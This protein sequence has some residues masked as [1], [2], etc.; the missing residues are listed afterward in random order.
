MSSMEGQHFG[1]DEDDV[2]CDCESDWTWSIPPTAAFRPGKELGLLTYREMYEKV[3]A[4]HTKVGGES[5]CVH[6]RLP[7]GDSR[8]GA[9]PHIVQFYCGH[10]RDYGEQC[11]R[12]PPKNPEALRAQRHEEK[13]R[14]KFTDCH[15]KCT[16]RRD[17]GPDDA[18]A[19]VRPA[20]PGHKQVTGHKMHLTNETKFLWYFDSPQRRQGIS[21]PKQDLHNWT[22]T[23]HLKNALPTG[24]V[25][26]AILTYIKNQV[27][28]CVA[29]PS[30]QSSILQEFGVYISDAQLYAALK[31]CNFSVTADGLIY[32][33]FDAP[34][35]HET[36]CVA[37]LKNLVAMKDHKVCVL[38]ENVEKST[39]TSSVFETYVKNFDS[40]DFVLVD[41][42]YDGTDCCK[43]SAPA[44]SGHVARQDEM[45][46]NGRIYDSARILKINGQQV[47]FVSVVW[48]QE[49]ELRNFSAFPEVLVMDDKKKTNK[50]RHSFFACIGVDSLWR[51]NTLFRAWSPNN[52]HD[53]LNWLMTIAFVKLVPPVLRQRVRCV[54]TDH[55]GVMTPILAKVCGDPDV[56]PCAK[57][58]LCIYHVVRNFFQDFG[59]GHTYMKKSRTKYR[60]GGEISWAY[61]W[62][63]NCASAIFRLGVCESASEFQ[64]C[65]KHVITY[66]KTTKQIANQNLR[67]DVL[68]F[69]AQKCADAD[70]W[71]MYARM[72]V[73]TF[74]I[75]S[76]SRAEGEFA[77]LR[78]LKLNAAMGFNKAMFKI[79]WQSDRRYTRKVAW[80]QRSMSTCIKRGSA[81]CVN[82]EEWK[83]LDSK[84]TGHYLNMI[85]H[86]MELEMC[87]T[88]RTL[89]FR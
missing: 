9:P 61:A 59:Q 2:W 76:T 75:S 89:N 50:Y 48:V 44:A 31:K 17:V 16:V 46:I 87:K 85:E 71:S 43:K 1:D 20:S 57:H 68:Q 18:C 73:R 55:C 25:T 30:M 39:D 3:I 60:K 54:F 14:T 19:V 12:K 77:G 81:H 82:L 52:T 29:V 62:Q 70:K 72:E 23:G 10:G 53:A 13:L 80:S 51:N 84:L 7:N 67:D 58:F 34:Y 24:K 26:E 22:H 56:L 40:S 33:S 42:Q 32:Q 79:R 78:H 86:Q 8:P 66:I 83:F 6:C 11:G 5:L 35:A 41:D 4:W 64:E 27:S 38:V 69:F 21:G 15:F 74:D 63:K 37:M 47:F 28:H 45:V 65:K 88:N 36:D 49:R